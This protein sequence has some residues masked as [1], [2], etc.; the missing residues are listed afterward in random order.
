MRPTG[1]SFQKQDTQ[2][3][4]ADQE[5]INKFSQLNM[6]YN[7]VKENIKKLKEELDNLEDAQMQVDEAM[8]EDLKL[9][10]GEAFISV[11]EDAATNYVEKVTE[12][13]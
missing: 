9:F 10:L 6:K 12:E 13:K 1:V 2:I 8:G 5:K 11:D 3:E 4:W 7:D